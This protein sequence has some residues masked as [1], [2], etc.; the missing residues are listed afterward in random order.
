[1]KHREIAMQVICSH[2]VHKDGL[3]KHSISSDKEKNKI[4]KQKRKLRKRNVFGTVV[5]PGELLPP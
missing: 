5:L 1:M 2:V 4:K 3:I